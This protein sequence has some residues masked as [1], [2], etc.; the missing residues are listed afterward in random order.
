MINS[1]YKIGLE[2][3]L[4]SLMD[5]DSKNYIYPNFVLLFSL[6]TVF[7]LH[8]LPYSSLGQSFSQ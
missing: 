1:F 4:F 6:D 7:Y 8:T 5:T 2:I 3:Q